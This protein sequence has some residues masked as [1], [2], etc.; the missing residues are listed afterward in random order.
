[1]IRLFIQSHRFSLS[2]VLA[3]TFAMRVLVPVGWMPSEAKGQMITICTGFGVSQAWLGHDGKIQKEAPPKKSHGDQPC[4]FSGLSMASMDIAAIIPTLRF[5]N[6]DSAIP[7]WVRIA[8]V[9]NGLAAPPP[10]S[11]GPPSLT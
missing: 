2:V 8:A 3:L 10:Y 5:V 11:T 1:V 6:V 9:G 7:S 4:V